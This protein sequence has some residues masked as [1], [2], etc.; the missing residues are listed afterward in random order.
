M[1]AI[2]DGDLAKLEKQV[3]TR[4][5]KQ[6]REEYEKLRRDLSSS[7]NETMA[8]IDRLDKQGLVYIKCL[9]EREHAESRELR[10]YQERWKKAHEELEKDQKR[11][12][13][14]IEPALEDSRRDTIKTIGSTELALKRLEREIDILTKDLAALRKEALTGADLKA[15]SDRIK[16]LE[17]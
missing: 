2:D 14:A 12:V 5:Q 13:E 3:E 8:A 15:L 7:H 17:K 9:G 10:D 4:L 6:F 1:A 16:K 11:R